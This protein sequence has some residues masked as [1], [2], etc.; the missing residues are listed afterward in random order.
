VLSHHE[1]IIS[2]FAIYF[3]QLANK[4][5]G[6]SHHSDMLWHLL[7]STVTTGRAIGLV[8]VAAKQNHFTGSFRLKTTTKCT[9]LLIHND[10]DIAYRA[11]SRLV[12]VDKPDY[13]RKSKRY[14]IDSV[15]WRHNDHPPR[16]RT[17]TSHAVHQIFPP[18]LTRCPLNDVTFF[19]GI[20]RL[21]LQSL[22][23]NIISPITSTR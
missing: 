17:V 6:F 7:S 23:Q 5:L 13:R 18:F 1:F 10:F 3:A 22:Q 9:I 14:P 11:K 20:R 4:W 8:A 12:S 15:F 2:F 16:C 21:T 19:A